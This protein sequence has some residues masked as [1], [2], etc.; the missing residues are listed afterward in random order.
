M[1]TR[2]RQGVCVCVCDLGRKGFARYH[3]SCRFT[4]FFYDFFFL[5]IHV[6]PKSKVIQKMVCVAGHMKLW[7]FEM[8]WSIH[9]KLKAAGLR[10]DG[11][12]GEL[13]RNLWPTFPI[14]FSRRHFDST[15]MLRSSNDLRLPFAFVRV[16]MLYSHFPN[17]LR[18]N[19]PR[20]N[21]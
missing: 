20:T 21:L 2:G 14:W 6:T 8:K 1:W 13:T 17:S 11:M 15:S 9:H 12:V 19:C 10:K 16:Y 3:L 4:L 18:T 5:I 7:A